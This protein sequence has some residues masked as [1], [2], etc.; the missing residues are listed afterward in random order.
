MSHTLM[1][2]RIREEDAGLGS[3]YCPSLRYPLRFGAIC[4]AANRRLSAAEPRLT[5]P[6][7]TGWKDT[8]SSVAAS[9]FGQQKVS[10]RGEAMVGP[11]RRRERERERRLRCEERGRKDKKSGGRK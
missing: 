5:A 9:R 6:N 8:T 10:S 4:R 1:M 3:G 11:E 2:N 7:S